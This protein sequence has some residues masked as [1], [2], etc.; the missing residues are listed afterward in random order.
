MNSL[1]EL[2]L[3]KMYSGQM[4][5]DSNSSLFLLQESPLYYLVSIN[6]PILKAVDTE[7]LSKQN[8]SGNNYSSELLVKGKSADSPIGAKKEI[9]FHCLTKSGGMHAIC[10]NGVL[11]VLLAKDEMHSIAISPE[12]VS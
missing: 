2:L 1:N 3:N 8:E 5:F 7:I 10:R 4:D 9:Y 11:W 6:L 12:M